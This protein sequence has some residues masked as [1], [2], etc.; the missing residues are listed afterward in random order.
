MSPPYQLEYSAAGDQ[1]SSYGPFP[2]RIGIGLYEATARVSSTLGF[3]HL[4]G[5]ASLSASCKSPFRLGKKRKY[6]LLIGRE[7]ALTPLGSLR[8]GDHA[9]DDVALFLVVEG[10][11]DLVKPH[12][13]KH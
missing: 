10:G 11:V 6:T 4:L 3:S 2:R 8:K 9:P 13:L 7:L 5:Q 12:S 1:P